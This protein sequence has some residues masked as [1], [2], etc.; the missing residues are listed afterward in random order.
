MNQ[1]LAKPSALSLPGLLNILYRGRRIV[2]LVTLA[3]LV[4]GLGYGFLTRP[5][6]RATA[7]VRPGIVSY[8]DIGAPVREWAI[9]DIVRWFR[10]FLY[11]ED[12]RELEAFAARK[13]PPVIDAEYIPS[14]PQYQQGGDVIT[15]TNLDPDPLAAVAV[16]RQAVASFNRQA[17][18][19]S[20]SS[21]MHLTIGGAEVRMARIRNDIAQLAAAEDRA[22]LEIGAHERALALLQADDR[23]LELR[24]ARLRSARAWRERAIATTEDDVVGAR[25]RLTEAEA[26]LGR[27]M[28]AEGGGSAAARTGDA[29]TDLLLQAS[30]R[31]QAG[32]VGE[33]LGTVDQLAARVMK[34]TV[35]ADTLRDRITAL[36]L[37]IAALQL[38]REVDLAKRRADIEQAIAD[39]QIR[40]ERDLPHQRAQLEVEWRG[41]EV[42]VGLLT[43]LEQIGRITVTD[44]PVRPRKLRAAAIL[45][46][47][48]F[49]SGMFL[50]LARE[51]YRRNRTAILAAED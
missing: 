49:C 50:V 16:L 30:R 9:R 18:L 25:A 13:G 45:T 33:L 8:S 27:V 26:L 47:L 11:W 5:L 31:E 41:E 7:Q 14:G 12:L 20:L 42:R 34:G 1:D 3:G 28:D 43:P 39:L 17:S 51:Y 44:Q 36:D 22:R 24:I 32:R 15:L 10:T 46:A 37:E 4:A 40:L 19:D 48:A 23:R 38:E 6:Y 29:E 35:A 2:A 21:T